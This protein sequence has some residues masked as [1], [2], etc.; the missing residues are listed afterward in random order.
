MKRRDK[1]HDV[2]A[3]DNKPVL[4][5]DLIPVWEAFGILSKQRRIAPAPNRISITEVECWCEM[6]QIHD[7]EEKLWYFKMIG[8]LDDVWMKKAAREIERARKK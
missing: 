2:P 6:N 7:P 1:G 3:L 4:F 8:A 5:D